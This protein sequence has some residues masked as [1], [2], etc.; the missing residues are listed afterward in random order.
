MSNAALRDRLAV[1]LIGGSMRRIAR[2]TSTYI[3]NGND[4]NID[5]S[6]RWG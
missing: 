2:D 1:R 5:C 3:I 4:R 6:V